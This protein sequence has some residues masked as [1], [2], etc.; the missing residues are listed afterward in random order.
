L[1]FAVR[2]SPFA[3]RRSPFGVRLGE[4]LFLTGVRQ[5]RYASALPLKSEQ[6]QTVRYKPIG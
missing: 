5:V 2:R 1:A 4:A 3:V 6:P